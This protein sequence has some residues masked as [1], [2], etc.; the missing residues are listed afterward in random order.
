[1][2]IKSIFSLLSAILIFSF[3]SFSSSFAD[4]KDINAPALSYVSHIIDDDDNGMSNGDADGQAEGGESIEM[5]LSVENT[6][7]Q[8]AHNVTATLFCAD[9]DIDIT[10]DSESFG[11]VLV[12]ETVWTINDFDFD[13][14]VGCPEKDVSFNVTFTSDEGVWVHSFMV[15]IFP[16]TGGPILAYFDHLI[17][18]DI[19]GESNGDGD[20]LVEGDESIEMPLA[21][22]N[23]GAS[24]AHTVSATLTCNDPDINITDGEEYFGAIAS[25]VEDWSNNDFDFIVAANC[26]EK[27]VVFTLNILAE[28][29]SW[30]SNFTIHIFEAGLPFLSYANHLIDDDDNGGSNG[31]G[32]GIP[33][34]GES[35]ELPLSILNSGEAVAQN[36][37]AVLSCNDPDIDITDFAES[38]PD[39][40]VGQEAWCNFN[41][42]FDISP[43]CPDKDVLFDLVITSDEG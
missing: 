35:I 37:S 42:N 22:F 4:N 36:V 30:T 18:D 8:I 31:D 28:E 1:M 13:V 41:F 40:L 27:D 33:E 10:D 9:G 25:G 26:P 12:G 6:G 17:D 3:N 14:V 15:H 20:G 11:D 2:Y 5:P 32:D 24:T 7:D 21:V 43:T 19:N 38:F 34:S 29:G 16:S 39:I 23:S